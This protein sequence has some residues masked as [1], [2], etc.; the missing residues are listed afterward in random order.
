[1]NLRYSQNLKKIIYY[2][3]LNRG[4]PGESAVKNV[5]VNAGE[6][7]RKDPLEENSN[8][9]QCSCLGNPVDRGA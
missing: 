5:P 8:P 2:Y 6:V 4:L 9:G 3:C 1:M 7:G